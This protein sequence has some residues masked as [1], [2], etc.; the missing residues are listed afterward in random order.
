ME[1]LHIFWLLIGPCIGVFIILLCIAIG[2]G[3][4]L[5]EGSSFKEIF[6]GENNN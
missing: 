3:V 1:S 5:T 6:K 2:F 4:R